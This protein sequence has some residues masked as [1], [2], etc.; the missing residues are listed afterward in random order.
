ME[1]VHDRV[2]GLDVA[3]ADVK[4]CVRTPGGRAGL[5]DTQ[6]RT[7]ATTTDGLLSARDWLAE[8]KVT[9]IAMEA[10]GD[11][12]RSPFYL[13]EGLC[14]VELVNAA[15]V[16]ALPGR[17]TDVSDAAWLAQLTECGLTRPS[18]VPPA[19]IRRLRDLTRYR[20]ALAAEV[21][22]EKNRLEKELEDAGIKLS[23]VAT[24]IFGVSGRAMIEALIAGQRD[25]Q[26]LT[27]LAKGRLRVKQ[28]ALQRAM[29]GRF[30]DHH[31]FLCRMHL[32]RIDAINR[33]MADLSRRINE[34]VAPFRHAVD[35]LTTVPGIS[36][37]IAEV[38]IAE[39]GADI[40]VFPTPAQLCSWAGVAPGNNQSGPRRKPAKTTPGDS[41]LRAALGI[42]AL[43]AARTKNTYLAASYHRWARRMPKL[44]A[45]VA[46]QHSILNSIWHMLKN[47]VAYHD[48][49][50]DHHTQRHPRRAVQQALH[51]LNA[52]GYTA[53][54][55]PIK[56]PTAAT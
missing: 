55:A 3:K 56:Q 51:T 49:G 26:A 31:G 36:V 17:K 38:I 45:I 29:L 35:L 54:L 11:Y 6:V 47:G 4:V 20:T 19:P 24:D 53:I 52:C 13:L 14:E 22:R 41:W 27:A 9:K 5:R 10:T 12:W 33:D 28:A 15:Q 32:D 34:V 2:A 16:K 8:Q 30:D 46:L 23:L 44:K 37:T 7:F 50:A 1:I 48:L 43:A 25:P 42:A 21:A 18:F 40:S 39:I